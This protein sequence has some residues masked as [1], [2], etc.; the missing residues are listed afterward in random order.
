MRQ[1]SVILTHGK[2]KTALKAEEKLRELK[3]AYD[4]ALEVEAAAAKSRQKAQAAF[5]RQL[6]KLKPKEK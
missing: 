1:P 3:K 6:A 2:S 5:E 4:D